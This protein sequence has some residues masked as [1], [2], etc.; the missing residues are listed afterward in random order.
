[1]QKVSIG[2]VFLCKRRGHF[3]T[4]IVADDGNYLY[5]RVRLSS[6]NR[7]MWIKTSRLLKPYRFIQT[8]KMAVIPAAP[9][10]PSPSVPAPETIPA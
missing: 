3:L 9:E 2:D 5:A 4:V 1:M 8:V 10:V 7:C 6:S